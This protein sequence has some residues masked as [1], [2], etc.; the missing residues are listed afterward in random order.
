MPLA[1]WG[2]PEM[3]FARL[4]QHRG[5]LGRLPLGAADAWSL[6]LLHDEV[7]IA[8][9]RL[10]QGEAVAEEGATPH[11]KATMLEGCEQVLDV[12]VDGHDGGGQVSATDHTQP[13]KR[14]F[15]TACCKRRSRPLVSVS[16]PALSS[17]IVSVAGLDGD[18][19]PVVQAGHR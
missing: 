10:S 16:W 4:Y 15:S 1:E 18:S 3:D 8:E 7:G 13:H 2:D 14:L 11:T 9:A 19:W 12:H 6:P 5:L 17:V